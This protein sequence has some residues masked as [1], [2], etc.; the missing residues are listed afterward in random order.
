MEGTWILAL[1]L[2]SCYFYN[3]YLFTELGDELHQLDWL[4]KTLREMEIKGEKAI[5][6]AHIP[7]GAEDCVDSFAIWYNAIAD[8]F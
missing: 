1:N 4:E 2:Q 3:F 7:P 6:I 5:I 8:R